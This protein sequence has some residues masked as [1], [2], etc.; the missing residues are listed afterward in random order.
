MTDNLKRSHPETRTPDFTSAKSS[1]HNSK[2]QKL[3]E[4][5]REIE[6]VRKKSKKSHATTPVEQDTRQ[7]EIAPKLT[8]ESNPVEY[9]TQKIKR[10]VEKCLKS[11]MKNDC[12]VGKITN[13]QDYKILADYH[14]TKIFNNLYRNVRYDKRKLSFEASVAKEN[15]RKICQ[16]MGKLGPVFSPEMLNLENYNDEMK[17]LKELKNKKKVH[18]KKR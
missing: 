17:S 13:L 11:Y 16:E 8:R 10:M 1:D 4:D 3:E 14:T 6:P 9:Y 5:V 7:V 2:R 12:V 18:K 15:W